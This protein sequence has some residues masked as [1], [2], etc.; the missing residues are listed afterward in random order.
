M[1]F[2]QSVLAG[3]VAVLCLA[4]LTSGAS[5]QELTL[6]GARFAI[7]CENGGN[8]SLIAGPAVVPGDVVIAHLF[9]GH[10][11]GV[12]VRLI[13]MGEGYRYAGPG[14]W[15]DGIRD[16]ALL[17]LSKYHPVACTVSRV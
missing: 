12:R 15:L 6:P 13:P 7:A 2:G 3:V 10:R 4:G 1:R 5:A 9:L 17:Y 11:G 14:V 16:H 8:Y